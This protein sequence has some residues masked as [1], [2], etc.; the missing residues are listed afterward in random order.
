VFW[1]IPLN[2]GSTINSE[3]NQDLLKSLGDASIGRFAADYKFAWAPSGAAIY[4]ERTLGAATNLWRIRVH[5]K[6]LQPIA[7]ERLTTSPGSETESSISPDGKYLAFTGESRHVQVWT[8]L[9]DARS[10][11][12]M[13]NGRLVTSPGIEA[14]APTL[15]Q[16]GQKMVFGGR[17]GGKWQ[18]WQ[19]A[20]SNEE[21]TP[22][23]VIDDSYERGYPVLS[24]D[25]TRI[26]YPRIKLQ[27]TQIVMWSNKSREEEV[28]SSDRDR[29]VYGWSPDGHALLISQWSPDT[30]RAEVWLLPL[31]ATGADESKARKIA[32]SPDYFL[33]QAQFSPDARWIAFEAIRNKGL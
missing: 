1:T 19:K 10:G 7:V 2:G 11:K 25:G 16:N 15:S 3:V 31:G 18:I 28:I 12:L 22:I 23:E 4:F 17:R 6:T 13:G 30:G 9:F 8:S 32:A 29:E 24:L 33:F 26:A 14:W 5:P 27:Q 21:E 20:F